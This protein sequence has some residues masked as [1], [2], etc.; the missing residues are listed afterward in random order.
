MLEAEGS[1]WKLKFSG[2][3]ERWQDTGNG[4]FGTSSCGSGTSG[5]PKSVL[6]SL[7]NTVCSRDE[8]ACL[9]PEGEG[10]NRVHLWAFELYEAG[11]IPYKQCQL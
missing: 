10:V 3:R 1:K 11:G 9:P 4:N 6:S 8:N 7:F 5:I 2:E